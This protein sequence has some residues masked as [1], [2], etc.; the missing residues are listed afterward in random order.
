MTNFPAGVKESDI[1]MYDGE[2][3]WKLCDHCG[4]DYPEDDVMEVE[5][6]VYCYGCAR[7]LLKFFTAKLT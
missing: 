1:D 5:E 6:R 3:V 4:D 7:E 2:I